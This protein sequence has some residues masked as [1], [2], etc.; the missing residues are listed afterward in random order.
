MSTSVA[1]ATLQVRH[2]FGVNAGVADNV[3]F[4]DDDTIVYVAGKISIHR[5]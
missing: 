4:T 3:S 1:S 5:R 2:I